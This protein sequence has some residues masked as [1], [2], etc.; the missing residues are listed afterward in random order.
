MKQLSLRFL[1]FA[2][3]MGLLLPT[4]ATA[5]VLCARNAVKPN[6]KG[7]IPLR[8]SFRSIETGQKCPRGHA[9]LIKLETS[10]GP[11]GEPGEKGER[12]VKGDS[13]EK[14]EPGASAFDTMPTGATIRGV[15][16]P[17]GDDVRIGMFTAVIPQTLATGDVV[18]ARNQV[19]GD[20]C[21]DAGMPNFSCLSDTE[22]AKDAS[23][24]TGTVDNPTAPPGKVCIYPRS[25][26]VEGR[27]FESRAGHSST[28]N[29]FLSGYN[30][31]FRPYFHVRVVVGGGSAFRWIDGTWAYTAP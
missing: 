18:I 15:M 19:L 30:Y 14:G 28:P 11:K 26:S 10:T 9:E 31:F 21:D 7:S 29:N 6:K 27:R 17:G 5:E 22:L 25:V 8:R 12:G 20:A 3:L 13:G 4:S 23:G 24:C 1:I 2:A 16:Q